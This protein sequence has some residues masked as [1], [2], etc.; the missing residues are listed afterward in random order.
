MKTKKTRNRK[1][2]FNLIKALYQKPT[3]HH[4]EPR[5]LGE[6]RFLAD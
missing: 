3:S 5:G 1:A 6:H 4:T 2:L